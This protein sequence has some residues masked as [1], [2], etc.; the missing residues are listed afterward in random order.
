MVSWVS[1]IDIV[2]GRV[3]DIEV[4]KVWKYCKKA[5]KGSDPKF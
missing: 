4:P 3:E 1:A 2:G 5:V